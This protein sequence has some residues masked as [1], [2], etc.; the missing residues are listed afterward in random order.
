MA[1]LFSVSPFFMAGYYPIPLLSS[2][3]CFFRR[4]KNRKKNFT[5]LF[6]SMGADI[7]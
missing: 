3:A 1:G 7:F 2:R 5:F 6:Q 4:F